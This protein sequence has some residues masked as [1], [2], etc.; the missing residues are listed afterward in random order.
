M[1]KEKD[2]KDLPAEIEGAFIP[3]VSAV[4]LQTKTIIELKAGRTYRKQLAASMIKGKYGEGVEIGS[5][6]GVKN[7]VFKEGTQYIMDAFNLG[8]GRPSSSKEETIITL[9]DG[10]KITH[11]TITSDVPITN[12]ITGQIIAFGRATCSTLESKYR[13]RG[14]ER[15]CPKCG[16]KTILKGLS[17]Y[18]GGWY[19][20]KKKGGCGAKF[21]DNEPKI[22]DQ[23]VGKVENLNPDDVRDTVTAMSIKR[24]TSRKVL[25]V[26]RMSLYLTSGYEDN[27]KEYHQS[28]QAENVA[29][30]EKAKRYRKDPPQKEEKKSKSESKNKDYRKLIF[31]N[32]NKI[33]EGNQNMAD[34]KLVQLS[35]YQFTDKKTGEVIKKKG[36]WDIEKL[37]EG[38]AQVV[39]HKLQKE[40]EIL[41]EGIILEGEE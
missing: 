13:Y 17:Q 3:A 7:M 14:E 40:L 37:T 4:T 11:Y 25:D 29:E 15:T 21:V 18:G 9:K 28:Q 6:P 2:L 1:S 20:N 24:A 26:T 5:V 34:K 23:I 30:E 33:F 8:T 12:L 19:C 35:T 32:L 22:I 10:T 38:E 39:W 41:N 16:E 27:G 31:E 36:T